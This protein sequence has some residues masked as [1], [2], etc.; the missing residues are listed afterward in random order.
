MKHCKQDFIRFLVGFS[1]VVFGSFF[2]PAASGLHVRA[3]TLIVTNNADSGRGTLREAVALA[4]SGDTVSF[5]RNIRRITLTGGEIFVD[6][7]LT[8]EGPGADRISLNGYRTS[9]IFYIA[10]RNKVTISGV[11]FEYGRSTDRG[12]AIFNEGTL[13]VQNSFLHS[14]SAREGGA[15]YST[16]NIRVENSTVF[17]NSAE[18]SGGIS[19]AANVDRADFYNSTISGNTAVTD[20]GG[21]LTSRSRVLFINHCTIVYNSANNSFSGGG[22]HV[23]TPNAF[24]SNT[25]IANNRGLYLNDV[26]GSI[27]SQ[28]SNLIGDANGSTGSWDVTDLFGVN[29]QLGPLQFNNGGTTPT[30]APLVG[31][32]AI[33]G[34]DES[35]TTAFDQTGANRLRGVNVDIGAIEFQPVV[36]TLTVQNGND[37]GFGSLREAIANSAPGDIINFTTDYVALASSITINKE[38]VLT[39]PGTNKLTIYGTIIDRNIPAPTLNI[40]AG[41][42]VRIS[43]LKFYNFGVENHGDVFLTNIAFESNGNPSYVRHAPL[44]S[45]AGSATVNNSLISD[46]VFARGIHIAGGKLIMNNSSVRRITRGFD[47][48]G[49]FFSGVVGRIKNSTISQNET[50]AGSFLRAGGIYLA[51]GYLSMI[52]TTIAGN[53][54]D[55]HG[56][57]LFAQ[58]GAFASLTNCTVTGNTST[59]WS[60]GIYSQNS[61]VQL[62]NSIVADNVNFSSYGNDKDVTGNIISGGQ[63]LIGMVGTSTGYVS[64]DLLNVVPLLFPLG[65]YG[66][67]TQTV[68]LQTGSPGINA[69][70]NYLAPATDQR[71]ISRLASGNSVDIGAYEYP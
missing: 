26:Y 31:S 42:K 45:V 64:T 69:G 51:S 71:G 44:F 36:Q 57:A 2:A 20:D 47:G 53:W 19:V 14:N 3:A 6:K 29:A 24:I 68:A 23:L 65:N 37:S 7:S 39:G 46:Y 9:R 49:I 28:G 5:D 22:V 40:S 21:G 43:D 18:L 10:R 34:G 63:N 58:S 55:Y 17:R 25:I 12:G 59:L 62:K 4:A 56:A 27:N 38:L 1:V 60:G 8:I 30:F 52:N 16:G 67:P 70:D 41:Y 50:L 32:P 54:A 66:G 13:A 61:N 35:I 11:T 15:I 48:S 33:D